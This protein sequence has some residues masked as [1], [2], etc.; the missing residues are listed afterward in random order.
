MLDAQG[1][2]RLGRGGEALTLP[3]EQNQHSRR[4]LKA[5]GTGG[6]GRKTGREAARRD[7]LG[8]NLANAAVT[9]TGTGS[10]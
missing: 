4:R 6:Q 8:G 7:G 1:Q 10:S 9:F 5:P 3:R 2:P